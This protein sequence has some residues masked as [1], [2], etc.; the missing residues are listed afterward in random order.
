MQNWEPTHDLT[1]E[2]HLAVFTLAVVCSSF[3]NDLSL[4]CSSKTSPEQFYGAVMMQLGIKVLSH[5]LYSSD[6][7][8]TDSHSIQALHAYRIHISS[9]LDNYQLYHKDFWHCKWN[10]FH[11]PNMLF[12]FLACFL[13]SATC[14]PLKVT[15][16]SFRCDR[17]LN[18]EWFHQTYDQFI[19]GHTWRFLFGLP[20]FL[21]FLSPPSPVSTKRWQE[22]ICATWELDRLTP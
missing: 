12:C 3:S 14:T 17:V 9:I 6:L 5:R 2:Q 1:D 19:K 13:F 21:Y 22:R 15:P 18:V 11:F 8:P 20:F 10:F 4:F 16:Y 7:S